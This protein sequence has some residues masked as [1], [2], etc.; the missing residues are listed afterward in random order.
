MSVWYGFEY[1][2]NQTIYKPFKETDKSCV[3]VACF[4]VPHVEILL[5]H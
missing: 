1:M 4:Q 3:G 5:S 2:Y